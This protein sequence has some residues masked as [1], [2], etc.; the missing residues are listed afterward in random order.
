MQDQKNSAGAGQASKPQP[1]NHQKVALIVASVAF[2]MLGM[3]YA[4]VPLYEMFCRVTGFAGTPVV[5]TAESAVRGNRTL[6][7]RFDA[8]VA[9]GLG[10]KFVAEQTSVRAQTGKT[11]TIFYKVTNPTSEPIKAMA[12]YNVSPDQSGSYFNKLQCFC[13]TEQTFEPG[14]TVD[15]AVVFFLD[16]ALEKDETMSG[17]EGVTLSYTFVAAKKSAAKAGARKSSL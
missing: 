3:S 16:P 7:V 10:L 15:M 8:N 13:F 1:P 6:T 12:T 2:L 9:P 14:K 4:A 11:M 17:I 5:A